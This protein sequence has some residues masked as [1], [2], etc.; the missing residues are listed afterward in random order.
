MATITV[1]SASH[2]KDVPPHS[3][4]LVLNFEPVTQDGEQVQR[5][6]WFTKSNTEL[7]APGSTI[8]GTLKKGQY[9]WE[10]KKAY[11]GGGFGGGGGRAKPVEERRSI[12]MQHAQKCAV[13]LLEL[14]CQYGTYKP[15][16]RVAEMAEHVEAVAQHLFRQVM[17]AEEGK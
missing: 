15:P 9:G 6:E 17:R 2:K 12:A 16:E 14:A 5:A 3:K 13:S 8:D 10:F 4:V 11:S 1:T 7:P